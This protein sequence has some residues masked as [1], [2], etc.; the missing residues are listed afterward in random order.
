MRIAIVTGASSG[1]GRE[2]AVWLDRLL[3]IDEVWLVARRRDRLEELAGILHRKTRIIE[4]DLSK[5]GQMDR[6]KDLLEDHEARVKILVNAAGYGKMGAFASGNRQDAAGQVR[7]NCQALTEMTH[8]VLP[9]MVR[10]GRIIQLASAAAFVPQMNFAVYAASK[11]YVLSF[12]RALNLE[13]KKKGITVTAV[14]PGPVRTE[15]FEIAEQGGETLALKKF[16][17]ISPTKVVRKALMA[18]LKKKE[19]C[20][21]SLSMR[22]M[23]LACKVLPHSAVLKVTSV[24]Y[25]GGKRK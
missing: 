22:L 21:P 11:S 13:L 3:E 7:I 14:C 16:F 9:Y 4:M 23:E 12:S 20:V 1:I 17:M 25:R 15:F 6:M 10:G 5:D 2:F 24:L 18:S 19:V 8:V